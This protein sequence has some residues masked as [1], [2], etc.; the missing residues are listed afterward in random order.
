MLVLHA[1]TV[2]DTTLTFTELQRRTGLAK[3]SLHRLLGDL[4]GARLLDRQRNRYRL[5]GMLFE[6]GMRAS[7]QRRLIEVA[8]PYLQTL[9][10]RTHETAH[11]GVREGDEVVYLSK[12]GGHRQADVPSRLGGRMPLH[13]TAIGKVLLANVPAAERERLV[14]RRLRRLTPRT[15]TAPGIL[16][17]QLVAAREQGVAY[18]FEESTIGIGCVAAPVLAA[19]HRAIAAVSITGPLARFDPARQVS[20]VKNAAGGIAA[21]LA[22]RGMTEV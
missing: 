3:A 14:N 18:E 10:E 8:V 19:D 12:I 7:V 16:D 22:R 11:L 15:I 13:A 2:E 4:V 20:A 6:L 17:R 1:F 9:C 5:S 21:A